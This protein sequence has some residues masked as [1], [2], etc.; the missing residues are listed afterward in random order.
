M[1]IPGALHTGVESGCLDTRSCLGSGHQAASL[2]EAV[3]L[4]KRLTTGDSADW[5]DPRE[6]R[7]QPSTEQPNGLLGGSYCPL[8]ESLA[9]DWW[10]LAVP[11]PRGTDDLVIYFPVC[12]SWSV[13]EGYFLLPVTLA[14][15]RKF[16][17]FEVCVSVCLILFRPLHCNN[18]GEQNWLI[19]CPLLSLPFDIFF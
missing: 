5:Q 8:L 18:G 6:G 17:F 9:A 11:F 2:T 10:V 16:H 14:G 3:I 7:G 1:K 4:R 13:Q 19:S 12:S 15:S